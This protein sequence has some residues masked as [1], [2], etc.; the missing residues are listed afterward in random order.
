[1]GIVDPF[2]S[3]WD[4][5]TSN[6]NLR[7]SG[8]DQLSQVKQFMSYCPQDI[9]LFEGSLIENLL[10]NSYEEIPKEKK[11]IE[12]LISYWFER[13]NLNYLLKRYKNF[14]ELMGLSIAKL[15]CGEMKRLGLIRSFLLDRQIEVY[16]EPTS[17]LDNENIDNVN[18]ILLERS[19]SKFIIATHESKLLNYAKNIIRI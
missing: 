14:D 16:D 13:L 1:M 8:E 15:S 10:M 11:E 12:E 18:Q 9:I 7:F 3:E 19:K 17:N 6:N 5:E 2:N 4:F